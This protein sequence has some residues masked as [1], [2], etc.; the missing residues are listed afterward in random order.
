MAALNLFR[1]VRVVE[2][3]CTT[4]NTRLAQLQNN[5]P[6]PILDAT[7]TTT[8]PPREP[9]LPSFLFTRAPVQKVHVL[10]GPPDPVRQRDLDPQHARHPRHPQAS[11]PHV[12]TGA[13]HPP[14]HCAV[15]AHGAGVAI[16]ARARLQS[17]GSVR[18][19]GRG[20]VGSGGRA[21][22]GGVANTTSPTS[23]GLASCSSR[24]TC[25]LMRWT[26]KG[27]SRR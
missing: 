20:G 7:T 13:R 2:A 18:S 24:C 22:S 26:M 17:K 16:R 25:A 9:P 14:G 21:A 5:T 8:P 3:M 19:S 27:N 11:G 10:P 1:R 6:P 15:S 12:R 23:S 4:L